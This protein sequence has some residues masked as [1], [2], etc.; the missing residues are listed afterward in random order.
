MGLNVLFG[1][2]D[3]PS[4]IAARAM[5]KVEQGGGEERRVTV[6]VVDQTCL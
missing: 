5:I 6:S 3:N 2:P 1:V 4:A